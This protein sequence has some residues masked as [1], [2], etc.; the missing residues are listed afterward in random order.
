MVVIKGERKEKGLER[1][2]GEGGERK[3]C[4]QEDED[5]RVSR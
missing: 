1:E 4:S 3:G 2:G 5:E